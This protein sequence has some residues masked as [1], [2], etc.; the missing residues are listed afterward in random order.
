MN[1]YYDQETQ[2]KKERS[3]I[4][5][6]SSSLQNNNLTNSLYPPSHWRME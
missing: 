2:T 6:L 4:E 5:N 1:T 3:S